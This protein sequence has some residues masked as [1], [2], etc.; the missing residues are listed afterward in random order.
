MTETPAIRYASPV[1]Q[2]PNSRNDARDAAL[3]VFALAMAPAIG[4]GIGRFAYALVLPD[5]QAAFGWSYAQAGTPNALNALGYLLGAMVAS[6]IAAATGALRLVIVSSIVAAACTM[7]S[8]VATGLVTLSALRLVAGVAGAFGLVAGGATAI[9]IA[10]RAGRRG[11]LVIAL[12]YAGPPAGIV[13]S[14]LATPAALS[15]EA[16][17]GWRAAWGAL[18]IVSFLLLLAF[19]APPLRRAAVALGAKPSAA[20]APAP[21][22]RFWPLL[23]GYAVFGAGY[24]TYMTFMIAFLREGGANVWREAAFWSTLGVAG[25]ASPWAF[26]R[27]L[28]RLNGGWGVAAA[29]AVTTLGGAAP[30]VARTL[31]AEFASAVVFGVGMFAT[32]AATTVFVRRNLAPAA[33][34]S[35]VGAL[36]VAFSLGQTAGPLLTGLVTDH[37]GDLNAG[38]AAGAAMLAI[39]AALSAAQRE[40]AAKPVAPAGRMPD[41]QI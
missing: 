13:M 1:L 25:M 36:T 41:D 15:V 12:F 9:A 27:V 28:G 23:A 11:A 22:R 19:L 34:A 14:A 2:P 21:L 6:R 10:E 31:P 20:R 8:A 30:L 33:W 5:M 29:I 39:G 35:G 32:T 40:L 26:S 24:I 3:A 7:L 18:G 17:E 37:F 4:L 38:L 16:I